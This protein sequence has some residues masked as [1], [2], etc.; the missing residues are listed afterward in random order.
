MI[1]EIRRGTIQWLADAERKPEEKTV[2][3]VFKNISELKRSVGKPRRRWLDHVENYVKKTGVRGRRKITR[4]KGHLDID[5]ERCQGPTWTVEQ[6]GRTRWE[7][8]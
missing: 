1:S 2:K 3:N 5:T 4:Y 7:D 6:G 8:I